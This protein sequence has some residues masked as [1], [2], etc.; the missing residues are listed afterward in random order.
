MARNFKDTFVMQCDY[1]T[2]QIGLTLGYSFSVPINVEDDMTD[3]VFR[4]AKRPTIGDTDSVTSCVLN[5]HL[6]NE[7]VNGYYKR[8]QNFLVGYNLTVGVKEYRS[9][10]DYWK[11]VEYV[12]SHSLAFITEYENTRT[13]TQLLLR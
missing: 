11:G 5:R 3:I 1:D 4:F 10:L 6:V 8:A 13:T 7:H 9:G 2:A 12:V